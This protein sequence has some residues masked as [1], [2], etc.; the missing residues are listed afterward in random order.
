MGQVIGRRATELAVQKAKTAGVAFVVARGSAHYGAASYYS[1]LIARENMIGFTTTGTTP[2]VA[3]WGGA[4]KVIG[5]DPL[6]IVVP[7]KRGNP[8]TLDISMSKVAGG[9]L[10]LAARNKEKIPIG[11]GIDKHGRHTDNPNGILDGGAHLPFGEH[12][13]YGLAVMMEILNGVLSGASVLGQIQSWTKYPENPSNI[14]QCF[15][16]VDIGSFIELKL[17][18]ARLRRF[19]GEIKASPP[20]SGIKE[21]LMP[22]EIEAAN[23]AARRK[24]GIPISPKVWGEL[25][26]LALEYGENP[27]KALK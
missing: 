18:R 1:A 17:F 4:G 9:K 12:K 20:M 23:E 22:G 11:W 21:I 27:E 14:G 8:I 7:F 16:A 13:G 15:A 5:N 19:V 6:S 26:S 24:D 10:K 2:S 3:A 25:E